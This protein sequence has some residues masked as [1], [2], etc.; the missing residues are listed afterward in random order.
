MRIPADRE[1]FTANL[2]VPPEGENESGWTCVLP[3][4]THI[5]HLLVSLESEPRLNL[6]LR[7]G[8]NRIRDVAINLLSDTEGVVFCYSGATISGPQ[9]E[10]TW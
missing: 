2:D 7:S 6:T 8:R 9:C 4:F 5:N 3:K 10:S 1:A